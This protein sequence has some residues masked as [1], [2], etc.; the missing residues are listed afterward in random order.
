MKRAVVG[1]FLVTL[2]AALVACGGGTETTFKLLPEVDRKAAPEFTVKMLNGPG[3]ISLSGLRGKPV[4]LN[5]WASWCEPC[6][7]ETPDLIAF[8]KAHPEVHVVGVAFQ[9]DIK[10]SREF[11]AEYGVTYQLGTDTAEKAQELFGFGGL[12]ATYYIDAQGR[13][14]AEQK[15]GPVKPADLNAFAA[16]LSGP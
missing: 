13:F 12:P 8:A 4:V 2:V 10:D 6:K 14:A 16:A 7:E 5:F 11:A 1:M 3:D 9:D 15:F